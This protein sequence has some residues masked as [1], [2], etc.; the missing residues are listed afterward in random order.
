MSKTSEEMSI[1]QIHFHIN[2]LWQVVFSQT[3]CI[4]YVTVTLFWDIM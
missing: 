3:T 4:Y 1:S 2:F